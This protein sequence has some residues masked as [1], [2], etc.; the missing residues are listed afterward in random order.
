MWPKTN[1]K[2]HNQPI[3]IDGHRFMS[4]KEG[5]RYGELRNLE[6]GGIIDQL[7]LQPRFPF[8]INGI[9]VCTYVADFAY[10]DVQRDEKIIEDVKGMVTDVFRIKK[11][12]MTAVL[13]LEVK[14]IC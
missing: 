14:I 5:A 11:K 1:S 4:K 12:L 8:V 7:E 3:V 9:K 10:R 2:Y 6:R 13:G